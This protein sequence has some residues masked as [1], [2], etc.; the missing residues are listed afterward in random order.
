MNYI[1]LVKIW[2][3]ENIHFVNNIFEVIKIK[4]L[5]IFLTLLFSTFTIFTCLAYELNKDDKI[6][7]GGEAIEDY[8]VQRPHPVA[9]S[10]RLYRGQEE[11]LL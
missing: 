1:T 10:F 9:K 8:E 5:I 7:V 6:Y 4:K 2:V 3:Y 11:L